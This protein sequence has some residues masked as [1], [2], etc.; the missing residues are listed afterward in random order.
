MP[1]KFWTGAIL[2][3]IAMP[4]FAQ[5]IKLPTP[6]IPRTPDGKADLRA[7]V[8]RKANGQPDL[9]GIWQV[10]GKYL[11]N[12][13]ADLKPGEVPFQPWAETVFNQ[14]RGGTRAKDDPA[15][16]CLPGMPKL[17]ALPYPFKIYD[18]PGAVVILYEGFTTYRQIFLDGRALP[19]DPQPTWMG[20]SVGR[21]EG[22]TL[23]VETVGIE[24]STWMDNAGHPHSDAL[25]LTERFTRRDFG[26]MDLQMT[27][28][29][30]KAYTK[31]WTIT[32]DP[33][34]IPDTE[35]LEWICENEKDYTH[36][37]K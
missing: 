34:L 1:A 16:R 32:E 13:A 23:V 29:D 20:Y 27:I 30:P 5:W 10:S 17:D 4:A 24:E 35:L 7:P 3:A 18:T 8:P 26:H 15:A 33:H 36:L 19:K 12:I 22:D 14:R 11:M 25:H 6:G 37:S 2:V 28:D 21:W 31:P 9:S